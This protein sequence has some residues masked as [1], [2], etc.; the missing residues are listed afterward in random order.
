MPSGECF[1]T[2]V[3]HDICVSVL[4]NGIQTDKEHFSCIIDIFPLELCRRRM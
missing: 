4:E 3:L 1:Y 2:I